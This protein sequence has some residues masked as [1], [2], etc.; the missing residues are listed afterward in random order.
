MEDILN[1]LIRRIC[2][3]V[4]GFVRLQLLLLISR[5]VLHSYEPPKN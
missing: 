4:Q 3:Y 1:Q 5:F 2:H